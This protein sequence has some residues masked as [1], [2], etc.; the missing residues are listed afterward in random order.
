MFKF[1]FDIDEDATEE[2]NVEPTPQSSDD[3]SKPTTMVIDEPSKEI[4][5]SQLVR[6]STLICPIHQ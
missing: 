2:V 5:L 6:L 4:S 3:E 1:D